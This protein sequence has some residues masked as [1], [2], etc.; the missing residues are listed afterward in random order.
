MVKLREKR[1][2][3][4]RAVFRSGR[5]LEGG[6]YFKLDPASWKFHV[7]DRSPIRQTFKLGKFITTAG[8][9]TINLVKL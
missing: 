1:L 6:A 3:E 5:L 8:K 4:R 2:F 9:S 7:M